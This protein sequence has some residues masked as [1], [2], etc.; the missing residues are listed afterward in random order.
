MT[1]EVLREFAENCGWT[2]CISPCLGF[3]PPDAPEVEHPHFICA[4][5]PDFENDLKAC[6][7]ALEDGYFPRISERERRYRLHRGLG[8]GYDL[9]LGWLVEVRGD[10][11]QEAIIK[12][13]NAAAKLKSSDKSEEG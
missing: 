8:G 10:T 3:V 1:P 4:S 9:S 6:F 12:A 7:E 2:K 5:L 11:K 13:V